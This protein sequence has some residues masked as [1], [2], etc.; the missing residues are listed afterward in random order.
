MYI[1]GGSEEGHIAMPVMYMHVTV[2]I[3]FTVTV[4]MESSF[5]CGMYVCIQLLFICDI[6]L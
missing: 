5:P 3:G 2:E 6:A 4:A 1:V